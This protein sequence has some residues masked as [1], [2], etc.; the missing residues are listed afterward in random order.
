MERYTI[1]P[2][3]QICKVIKREIAHLISIAKQT[4]DEFYVYAINYNNEEKN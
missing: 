2:K 1:L 4:E 3:N